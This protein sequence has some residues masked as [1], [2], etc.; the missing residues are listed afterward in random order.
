MLR[1]SKDSEFLLP[2]NLNEAGLKSNGLISLAAKIPRQD[3]FQAVARLLLTTFVQI[4][5]A[6]AWRDR[7]PCCLKGK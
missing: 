6:Q 1:P 4:Y 7:K 5:N 2:E 3:S